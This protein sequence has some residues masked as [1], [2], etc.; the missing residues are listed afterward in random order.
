MAYSYSFTADA[1]VSD[2]D[3]TKTTDY[4]KIAENTDAN[5][6]VIDVEHALGDGTHQGINCTGIDKTGG[7][8]SVG[9]GTKRLLIP[10]LDSDDTS[11][12]D[13]GIVGLQPCVDYGPT[14]DEISYFNFP[15]PCDCD[16]T[17]DILLRLGYCMSTA[18]AGDAVMAIAYDVIA[19]SGDI[20]PA[21]NTD[22]D[23]ETIDPSDTAEILEYNTGLAIANADISALTN[24]IGVK[25]YR[26]ADN[27][28]DTHTG[29]FRLVTLELQYT[30]ID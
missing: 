11:P 9:S 6:E 13:A 28:A 24:T 22:T 23:S 29:D 12:P 7:S 30:T 27:G 20:T 26:D 17:A 8:G 19:A 18:N 1:S 5:R 14:S 3:P 2:E 4:N 25:L 21:A 15:I 10:S 16:I